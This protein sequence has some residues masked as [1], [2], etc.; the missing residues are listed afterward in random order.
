MKG[1]LNTRRPFPSS[2]LNYYAELVTLESLE[3]K[4]IAMAAMKR[5]PSLGKINE[6]KPTAVLGMANEL[7]QCWSLVD[8]EIWG[9][10]SPKC[11]SDF[12]VHCFEVW[13]VMY[14]IGTNKRRK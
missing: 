7:H 4:L 10:K 6:A 12:L 9:N 3:E 1:H 14:H 11:G 8:N 2:D 5:D 13:F